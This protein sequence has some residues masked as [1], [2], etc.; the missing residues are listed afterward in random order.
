MARSWQTAVSL[1]GA[2][3]HHQYLSVHL[4]NCSS[5]LTFPPQPPR[6]PSTPQASGSLWLLW[7]YE[8]ACISIYRG[9]QLHQRPRQLLCSQQKHLDRQIWSLLLFIHSS[10][11]VS[12][13]TRPG[14]TTQFIVLVVKNHIC[15]RQEGRAFDP[16]FV[17]QCLTKLGGSLG[18]EE[19]IRCWRGSFYHRVIYKAPSIFAKIMSHEAQSPFPASLGSRK[20]IFQSMS[21]LFLLEEIFSHVDFF[22]HLPTGENRVFTLSSHA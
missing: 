21:F 12:F 5:N 17:A 3:R 13:L 2:A 9:M 6:H 4:G 14:S 15:F 8:P 20:N 7:S 18:R 10:K 11:L 1:W 22:S 19:L 16:L